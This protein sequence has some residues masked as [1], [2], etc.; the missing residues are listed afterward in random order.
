MTMPNKEKISGLMIPNVRVHLANCPIIRTGFFTAWKIDEVIG[1]AVLEH[2]N[3]NN[4]AGKRFISFNPKEMPL[5][6]EEP[7][8]DK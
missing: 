8:T 4:K 2:I 5:A 6:T 7:D 1:N 3:F